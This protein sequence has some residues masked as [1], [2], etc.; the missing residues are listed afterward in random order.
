ML[1]ATF[2]AGMTL[3]LITD[4]LLRRGAGEA[5]IGQV[6]AANTLGAIAGVLLAVHIGLPL[7]GLKGTL[8]AGQRWSTRRSASLLLG[9]S[10]RQRCRHAAGARLRG[11]VPAAR[12]RL[13]ARRQ[14]DDR[15]RVPPRRPR[16]LAR[17]QDP[18]TRRT[19]RPPPCTWCSTPRRPASA[20]TASPTA[21]STSTAA[22]ER[23]SRRDHHGAH[24]R[25]AARAQARGEERRGDR[26]RHR[27]HH[28]H[29]AAEPGDR[30]RRD[31]RDR[32]GDGGGRARLHAA[33]QRRL[34][35]SAQPHPDRRRQ[36]LLLHAQPALRH[37]HLRAL[38]PLGERRVEPVHAR[39]LPAHP[40]P[41]QPGRPAGAVVPALRDRRLARS[42]R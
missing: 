10:P 4:A 26:H 34:R 12:A 7:L 22:G 1:P 3:P 6:Y 29:A 41:P 18:V 8:I 30:A 13:R 28:A 5:A 40:R 37:H 32:G 27:P 15:R 31:R 42:P 39:V 20:P 23:G 16:E 21:P 33:Q 17:R 14:Q 25:A 9:R 24:R 35:R 11:A 2:C 19:A 36:D 38:Q